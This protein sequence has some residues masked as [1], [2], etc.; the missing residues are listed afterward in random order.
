M[1]YLITEHISDEESDMDKEKIYLQLLDCIESLPEKMQHIVKLK[2]LHGYSYA[3]ISTELDI[4][5][6]TV[7]TQLKR[8]KVKIMEFVSILII[9]LQAN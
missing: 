8:A 6:N 9:L 4:S 2:F 3:E 5:I 7:K 1:I